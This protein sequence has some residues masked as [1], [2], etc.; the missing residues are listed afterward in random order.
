ML[1]FIYRI[2]REI[3]QMNLFTKHKHTH[4]L[5]NKLTVTRGE[6]KGRGRDS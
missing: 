2:L 5:E 1:S 6:G 4:R 3:I